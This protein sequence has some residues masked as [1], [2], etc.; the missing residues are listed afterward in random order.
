MIKG[1]LKYKKE[2]T[3]EGKTLLTGSFTVFI[4]QQILLGW[5]I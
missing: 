4:T 3:G 1:M 2:A 5:L